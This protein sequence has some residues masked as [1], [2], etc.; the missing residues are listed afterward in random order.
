MIHKFK[1]FRPNKSFLVLIVSV[2]LGLVAALVARSYMSNRIEEIESGHK[3]K[4]IE[5]V[6]AKADLERGAILTPETVAIRQIPLDFAHEQ[7]I[8][9]ATYDAAAG[10]TLAFA[11]KSGQLI[12]WPMLQEKKAPAFSHRVE[13]GRRAMTVPVDEISSISGM[14]EPGDMIDLMVTVDRSG[15]KITLPLLQ[16]VQVLAT[17]QRS[18]DDPKSGE[19]REYSTVTLD[20]TPKQAQQVIAAREEGRIT[21]LL[22]NPQDKEM[23]AD[24]ALNLDSLLGPQVTAPAQATSS[25]ESS[26]DVIPILYGGGS[27]NY[28]SEQVNLRQKGRLLEILNS[29]GVRTDQEIESGA[30]ADTVKEVK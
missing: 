24:A 22:R 17:G 18:I 19:R 29:M 12:L 9:P 10:E 16:N 14:L 30:V 11:V 5:V 21:A 4:L 27:A 25:P 23:L 8:T 7:A 1:S 13:V 2:V 6:V 28:T 15:R 3:G 20:T 26:K